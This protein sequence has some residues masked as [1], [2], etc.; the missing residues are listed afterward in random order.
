MRKREKNLFCVA[1]TQELEI[2]KFQEQKS[3]IML[4]CERQGIFLFYL[5][6]SKNDDKI[7]I[8]DDANW[9]KV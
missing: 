1:F 4:H 9:R 3:A 6:L 7:H 2:P 8:S 5:K